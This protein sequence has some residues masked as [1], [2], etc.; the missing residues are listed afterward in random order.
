[1]SAETSHDEESLVKAPELDECNQYVE[2]IS[3]LFDPKRVLLRRTFFINEDYS[4]YMLDFILHATINHWW[5]S[6]HIRNV[7]FSYHIMCARSPNIYHVCV[8]PC[9]ERNIIPVLTVNSKWLRQ[10]AIVQPK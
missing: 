9:V 7:R 10:E 1:M 8:M 3:P 4:K 5:K 2:N 6:E